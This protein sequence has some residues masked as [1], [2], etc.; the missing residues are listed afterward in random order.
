MVTK[1][2]SFD[3]EGH[4]IGCEEDCV[5]TSLRYL[6][7]LSVACFTDLVK[8]QWKSNLSDTDTHG[9]I[10]LKLVLDINQTQP[11]LGKV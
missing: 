8:P 1:L 11:N 2:W 5:Y 3:C 6:M 7:I 9:S 4:V 10:I